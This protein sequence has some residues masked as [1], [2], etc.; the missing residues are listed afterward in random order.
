MEREKIR[1]KKE[2][3]DW[4]EKNVKYEY[5]LN[6]EYRN[7]KRRIF[8]RSIFNCSDEVKNERQKRRK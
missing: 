7:S 6:D 1:N 3:L 8:E 4:I 2:L 5:Y